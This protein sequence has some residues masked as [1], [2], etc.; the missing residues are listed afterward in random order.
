[1]ASRWIS[2]LAFTKE[3]LDA[4][5]VGLEKLVIN[6]SHP[7]ALDSD[8]FDSPIYIKPEEMRSL[9]RL[10]ELSELRILDMRDSFQSIIWEAVYKNKSTIRVLDLQMAA[11]PVIHYQAWVKAEDV[12]GLL[13]VDDVE[14]NS[15]K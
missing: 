11:P 5:P 12:C 15:I 13:V 8:D 7:V 1:M 4:L 14:R 9:T 10:T 3:A 6:V 2:S